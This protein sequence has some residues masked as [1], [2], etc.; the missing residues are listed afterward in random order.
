MFTHSFF[1]F[2]HSTSIQFLFSTPL[3]IDDEAATSSAAEEGQLPEGSSPSPP[4]P[5]NHLPLPD[6]PI[7]TNFITADFASTVGS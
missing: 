5:S 6:R 3:L 2:S 7:I 1:Q 4:F